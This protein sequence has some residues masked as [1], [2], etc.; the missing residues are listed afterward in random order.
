MMCFFR[1]VVYPEMKKSVLYN[2]EV[3][4]SDGDIAYTRCECAAGHGPHGICKHVTTVLLMVRHFG[5]EGTWLMEKSCTEMPQQWH[6][7]GKNRIIASDDPVP[8][9]ASQMKGAHLLYDPRPPSQRGNSEAKR[10]RLESQ[11]INFC[12]QKTE[13]LAICGMLGAEV[14]VAALQHDHDYLDVPLSSQW[15]QNL[16]FLSVEDIAMVE[17]RTRGQAH[18]KEWAEQRRV[19]LTASAAGR[20]CRVKTADRDNLALHLYEQPPLKT[21]AVTWGRTNEGKALAAYTRKTGRAVEKAGLFISVTEPYLAASPDGVCEDR[22]VEVKCPFKKGVRDSPCVLT[23]GYTP[24]CADEN[25]EASLRTN[26]PYFYQVQLQMFCA[27]KDMCDFVVYTA[28]DV[29]IVTVLRDDVFIGEMVA[30]MHM[31]Y[32]QYYAPLLKKKIFRC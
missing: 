18:S 5:A 8:L 19:R 21:A 17:T 23:S 4:V 10:Q 32:K 2:V 26:H 27:E 13:K 7:R 20:I 15:L 24:I 25:G 14:N 22:I 12:S 29:C 31:F 9:E 1:A 30:K 28:K 16:I 3:R 11:V 6:R